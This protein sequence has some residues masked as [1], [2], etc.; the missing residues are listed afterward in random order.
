MTN[1][2]AMELVVLGVI[3]LLFAARFISGRGVSVR[4]PALILKRFD[5]RPA[6]PRAI[7][8]L[9]GRRRGLIGWFMSNI[10]LDITTT[11]SITRDSVYVSKSSLSGRVRQTAP[12]HNIASTHCG[13]SMNLV[14]LVLAGLVL[15]SS[16]AGAANERSIWPLVPGL[17]LSLLFGWG[18]LL[19]KCL[20]IAF[21][22]N[23]GTVL[24]VRFKRGI[25]ENVP[26]T[27]EQLETVIAL[28]NQQTQGWPTPEPSAPYAMKTSP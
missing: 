8:N 2:G 12:A 17:L 11:L 27:V 9:V 26:V 28:F 15:L 6:D 7:L 25:I 1:L 4:G 23:G 10:G 18:F 16:L 3:V 21:E 20:L 14:P 22:T 13:Y 5:N 19:S 24:G